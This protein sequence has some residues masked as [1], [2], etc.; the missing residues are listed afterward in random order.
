MYNGDKGSDTMLS[1]AYIVPHPPIILSE[2]GRGQER[3]IQNTVNA[4]RMIAHDIA[5]AK[6]QTIVVFSPHV[7]SYRDYIQISDGAQAFG[8]FEAFGVKDVD[9]KVLYDED[10]V[11]MLCHAAASQGL[12]A[13]TL[14]EQS[15]TL[16]HGTMVPLHFILQEYTDF[17][18]VRI[19]VSGLD[20][21]TQVAFGNCL[22]RVI[23][24]S[25]RNVA[26][27]ASGDLSHK[28][29]AD[30]PYGFHPMGPV[31]DEQIVDII[32]SNDYARLLTM[33]E[34][35]IEESANCGYP[36]FVMLYG[37]LQAY[38]IDSQFLSY[39]GPFGVGYATA[40]ISV[41]KKDP[42][43]ALA[44]ES[45]EVYICSHTV[46]PLRKSLPKDLLT[47]R[48]G[49]FVSLKKFGELRG[50]IGT[51]APVQE[52]LA[53]EIISNAISAGTRDPRFLPV[54]EKELPYLEY[55]VDVL[56]E[57]EQIDS[58]EQLDVRR[59]GVIV[60]DEHR[61]GLLLPDLEGVDTPLQQISIA[62]N[63]AGMDPYEPFLLERFEVVR[64]HECRM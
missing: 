26:V 54:E 23:D 21:D 11:D 43:V 2:I 13:G 9:M 31:F 34:Q 17:R 57:A 50:C 38:P 37:V 6:P 20:R 8:S 62:L 49:V 22:R 24:E 45:L 47:C 44:R 29:K 18:L 52:N 7:P 35:I 16:D 41:L 48:G 19:S 46:L 12:P 40:I 60:S 30:G 4:Y 51:I 39:E 36:A 15:Q 27:I 25:Q 61:R 64:H 1:K 59:Y 32:K 14:G 58:L 3:V 33:D 53:Q 5:S 63:K 10:F 56:K 28:L 42:Y 55:S